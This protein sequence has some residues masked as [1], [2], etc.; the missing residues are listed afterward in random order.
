MAGFA[1]PKCKTESV[2]FPAMTG[3]GKKMAEEMDVSF[4]GGIPLDPRIAKACD[5]GVS[6]IES[7]PDSASAKSYMDIISK[8]KDFVGMK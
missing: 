8:I 2:V 3:G 5:D 6:F 1:C 7:F 4:L